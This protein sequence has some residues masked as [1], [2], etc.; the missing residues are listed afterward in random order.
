[1]SLQ[2]ALAAHGTL[3]SLQRV[4]L[5]LVCA[6]AGLLDLVLVGFG[7]GG[8]IKVQSGKAFSHIGAGAGVAIR[9][10]EIGINVFGCGKI[11]TLFVDGEQQLS[12][13]L[14]NGLDNHIRGAAEQA[15]HMYSPLGSE[16]VETFR[17]NSI[18]KLL[19]D[20]NRI[21]AAEQSILKIPRNM[22]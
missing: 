12:A 15:G 22:T 20:S 13:I 10:G 9:I 5:L 11:K 1:M 7:Q 8:G 19:A 6:F 17:G 14:N 18:E 16:L 2:E 21:Y 4:D 3:G